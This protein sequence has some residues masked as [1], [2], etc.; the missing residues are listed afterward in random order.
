MLA[1]TRTTAMAAFDSRAQAERAI[2]DLQRAGFGPDQIGFITRRNEGVLTDATDTEVRAE[3]GAA[4][5]AVT[6]GILGALV[7][8]AVALSLPGVGPILAAGLLA[9]VLGASA[10]GAWGGGL[11]G[12]LIGLTL[13]EEEARYYE[14][15]L[16]A[17]RALVMVQA[18]DRYTE[19]MDILA[20]NGGTYL[21][22][23]TTTPHV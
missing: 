4:A 2:E 10:A 14:E 11:L 8:G 22:P 20:R 3:S 23:F 6:G 7:G 12:A 9:G 19:A 13:P 1:T 21:D 15:E 17:G 5:G 16:Q 18:G